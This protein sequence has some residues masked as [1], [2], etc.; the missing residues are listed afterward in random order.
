MNTNKKTLLLLLCALAV[1]TVTAMATLRSQNQ[2]P[3]SRN[4]QQKVETDDSHWPVADY[5]AI[6]PSDAK[7][8]TVRKNRG[9]RYDNW[10]V[11]DGAS[12]RPG[13]TITSEI[14]YP[15]LPVA[16]SDVVL[17]GEVSDARAYLSN[18]KSGVYSEFMTRV[19]AV[20]KQDLQA[21]VNREDFVATERAG[22]SG[23]RQDE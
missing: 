7:T 10:N 18:D 15:A 13:V 6:E 16:D 9:K 4:G 2:Q 19:C 23:I 8:K 20:M 14:E 12:E 11:I 22:E 1:V 3:A 21:P 5:E 17:I